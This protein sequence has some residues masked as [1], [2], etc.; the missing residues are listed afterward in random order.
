[1]DFLTNLV[2]AVPSLL[3]PTNP[4]QNVTFLQNAFITTFLA[5]LAV[6]TTRDILGSRYRLENDPMCGV[7]TGG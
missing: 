5:S 1:M 7:T 4:L 6:E 2:P 3:D